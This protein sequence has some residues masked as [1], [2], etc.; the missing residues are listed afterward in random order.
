MSAASS[1]SAIAPAAIPAAV[2]APAPESAAETSANDAPPQRG[3]DKPGYELIWSDEFNRDGAPDAGKWSFD[4]FAN[5]QG[6]FGGELQYYAADRPENARVEDGRLIITAR[7]ESLSDRP[8]HGGQAYSSARLSSVGKGEFTYGFFEV[9]AKL[10]CGLG[11]WPAIW[12]LGA[13]KPWP[14]GGSIDLMEFDQSGRAVLGTLHNLST[15]GKGGSGGRFPLA[16]ACDAFHN[17]QL[18][19][20]PQAIEFAV[21]GE[22]YHRYENAGTGIAQWPFDYPHYL[23]LSLAIRPTIAEAEGSDAFFPARFEID[24]V[25]VYRPVANDA[26]GKVADMP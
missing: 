4:T 21:D 18:S 22:V 20:T 9:R 16:D 7:R 3:Y 17:Y 10:P 14:E 23:I 11:L 24:H 13:E 26:S 6:W 5:K 1:A 25:R 15:E 19:W 2:P 12:T 8:D